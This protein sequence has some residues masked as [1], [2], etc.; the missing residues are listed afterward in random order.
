MESDFRRR[1]WNEAIFLVI[2]FN[3]FVKFNFFLNYV[4]V[5]FILL[6]WNFCLRWIL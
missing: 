3:F 5:E 6:S 2:V 1:D 4:F